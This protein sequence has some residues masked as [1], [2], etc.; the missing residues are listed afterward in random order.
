[1]EPLITLGKRGDLHARRQAASYLFG[2][3][4]VM[5]LFGEVAQRFKSRA[6]GYTRI[7]RLGRR[8]GDGAEMALLEL[9]PAAKPA[10][11]EKKSEITA[12]AESK[13]AKKKTAAEGTPKKPK[14]KSS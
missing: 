8:R 7:F 12:K 2:H 3:A 9:I 4:V 11:K 5:K 14:S 6:G 10:K 13:P 1:V